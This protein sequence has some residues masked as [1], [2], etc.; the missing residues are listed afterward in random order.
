MSHLTSPF[1]LCTLLFLLTSVPVGRAAPSGNDGGLSGKGQI[2][3][4][5][6]GQTHG[7]DVVTVVGGLGQSDG[8]QVVDQV[9]GVPA[10]VDVEVSG[11]HEDPVLGG[12]GLGEHVVCAQDGDHGGSAEGTE[13]R[14]LVK[15]ITKKRSLLTCPSSEQQS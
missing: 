3:L 4:T 5:P 1:S 2:Q 11:G 14:A 8:G 13:K 7:V 9:L 6:V 10:G 12:L 15:V